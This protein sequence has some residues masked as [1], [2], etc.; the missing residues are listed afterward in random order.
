MSIGKFIV[1]D[2]IDGSG[3]TTHT[4][5]LAENLWKTYG[6]DV[7]CTNEPTNTPIGK[8]IRGLFTDSGSTLPSWDTMA[9]LFTADRLQ[10]IHDVI[11]PALMDGKIVICDRYYHSTMAYQSY[12]AKLCGVMHSGI[13]TVNLLNRL[14]TQKPDHVIILNVPLDVASDRMSKRGTSDKF[15][16]NI[17]LQKYLVDFYARMGSYFTKES[18]THILVD[19]TSKKDDVAKSILESCS[20]LFKN[21]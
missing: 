6:A 18:I 14:V 10:H 16:Q 1:L 5:L 3:T 21:A 20:F 19:E 13:A 4:K 9:A 12:Y 7:I 17:E 2:G 8:F 11:L 15:E